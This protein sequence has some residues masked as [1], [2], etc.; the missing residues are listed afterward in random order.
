MSDSEDW[1]EELTEEEKMANLRERW[2]TLTPHE[3]EIAR[4]TMGSSGM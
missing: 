4:R 1:S 2:K 3:K